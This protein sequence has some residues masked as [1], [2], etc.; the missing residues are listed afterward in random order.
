MIDDVGKGMYSCVGGGGR[1]WGS[2]M[3]NGPTGTVVSS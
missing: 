1:G 3:E 2:L